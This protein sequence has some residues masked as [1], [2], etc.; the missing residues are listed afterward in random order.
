MALRPGGLQEESR[1]HRWGRQLQENYPLFLEAT[2]K[3]TRKL[4]KKL[5]KKLGA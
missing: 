5:D 4:I 1:L 3:A 2:R